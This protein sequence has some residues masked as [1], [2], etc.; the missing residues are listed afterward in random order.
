MSMGSAMQKI[1]AVDVVINEMHSNHL[2]F[3]WMFE[4]DQGNGCFL[5]D[6]ITQIIL[7]SCNPF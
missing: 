7:V 5:R 4:K 1:S 2:S 3:R 6:N